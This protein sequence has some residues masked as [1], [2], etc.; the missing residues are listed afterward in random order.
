MYL[1][2]VRNIT[3]VSSGVG[4][5]VSTV[6]VNLLFPLTIDGARVGLMDADIHIRTSD[7]AWGQ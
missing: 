3:A 1:P 6:A 7:H 4:G 2:G 5:S